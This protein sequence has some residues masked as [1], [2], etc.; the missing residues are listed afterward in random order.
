MPCAPSWPPRTRASSRWP[1]LDLSV[2]Q[3][4]VS[5]RIAAL[6]K[7]LGVRLFTRTAARSQLTIDGQAFLPHARDLL[8]PRSGRPPPCARPCAARRRDQPAARPG[9]LLRGFHRAHPEV[10][11]DVVT[12]STSSGRR[13]R[14]V[15]HDRRVLRAA[16]PA[17]TARRHRGRPGLRRAV[18]LLTG[19]PT[20]WPAPGGHASLSL[21]GTGSGCPA[22][23]PEPS[24][25]PT[26][27][28][29][30]AFGLTID[31]TGPDFGTEPLL[32]VIADSPDLATLVGEQTRFVWPAATT[33][34]ASR[35][36][37]D[38]RLP[39]LTDLARRQP[40]PGAQHA[41]RVPRRRGG[42]GR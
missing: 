22:S 18:Q 17:P 40:A 10:E 37:P 2:T 36:R 31:T 25:P 33:C 34:G 14:P 7:D 30:A 6:E 27:T 16:L 32:D 23:S 19:R 28:L 13:R 5:K 38:A 1:P 26:T 39:A 21:P 35:A 9:D 41:P 24:G 20:R 29:A 15:G 11:L 3:Q 8:R 4:A 12:S 42:S